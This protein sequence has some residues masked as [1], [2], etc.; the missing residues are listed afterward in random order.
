MLCVD[1]SLKHVHCDLSS[2]S[3]LEP[4]KILGAAGLRT[5]K[6]IVDV[7]CGKGQLAL[8][9]SRLIGDFE[10][11]YGI[12]LRANRGITSYP[13]PQIHSRVTSSHRSGA[14]NPAL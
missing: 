9:A 13:S 5:G 4:W 6:D 8:A 3:I 11:V 10:T 12:D 14:K 7:G 2:K 1:G